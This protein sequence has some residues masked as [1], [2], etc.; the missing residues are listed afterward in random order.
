MAFVF[1]LFSRVSIVESRK[2]VP[3]ASPYWSSLTSVALHLR[4]ALIAL[5]RV[6]D[7]I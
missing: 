2:Y 3:F 6:E 5:L 7:S 1:F 4:Y